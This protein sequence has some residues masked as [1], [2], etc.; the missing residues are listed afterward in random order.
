[1]TKNKLNFLV[2]FLAAICFLVIAK[3]GLIIFFFLPEGVRRGGYQEF[4]GITKKTYT[5]IHNW[6]GIVFVVLIL[7]HIVLHW[8]W[9]INAVKNFFRKNGQIQQ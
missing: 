3:T 1:M 5:G 9:I 6:A 8:D 7:L 4:F 2:D